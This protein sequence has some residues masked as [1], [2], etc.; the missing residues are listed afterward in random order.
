MGGGGWGGGWFG[1]VFGS[2]GGAISDAAQTVM[3]GV[4]HVSPL[5][6]HLTDPL[7]HILNQG[8]INIPGTDLS[9]SLA[10]MLMGPLLAIPYELWRRVNS[11]D[12]SPHVSVIPLSI[13]P[14]FADLQ[15]YINN[16]NTGLVA[17]KTPGDFSNPSEVQKYFAEDNTGYNY[18]DVCVTVPNSTLQLIFSAS[19]FAKTDGF[20]NINVCYLGTEESCNCNSPTEESINMMGVGFSSINPQ[21]TYPVSC[22]GMSYVGDNNNGLSTGGR[23]EVGTLNDAE[24]QIIQK[25]GSKYSTDIDIND[26]AYN[27]EKSR[28]LDLVYTY[29]GTTWIRQQN[30]LE[31][32][33]YHT[34]VGNNTHAIF[35]GG[36][37]DTLTNYSFSYHDKISNIP[38][39]NF[40]QFNFDNKYTTQILSEKLYGTHTDSA[41]LKSSCWTNPAWN[42]HTNFNQ[43]PYMIVDN[44]TYTPS[45]TTNYM[46]FIRDADFPLVNFSSIQPN[47]SFEFGDAVKLYKTVI[48][49]TICVSQIDSGGWGGWG[50]SLGVAIDGIFGGGGWDGYCNAYTQ[51]KQVSETL[52]E[53]ISGAHVSFIY[54]TIDVMQITANFDAAF[55]NSRKRTKSTTCCPAGPPRARPR[56]PPRSLAQPPWAAMPPT[57]HR[58]RRARLTSK[59]RARQGAA[60]K[61]WSPPL[62]PLPPPPP[63]PPTTTRRRRTSTS[64]P[65]PRPRPPCL[66]SRGPR[67]RLPTRQQHQLPHP[68]PLVAL[69]T[70]ARRPRSGRRPSAAAAPPGG[71]PRPCCPPTRAAGPPPPWRARGGGPRRRPTRRPARGGTR[72]TARRRPSRCSPGRGPRRP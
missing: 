13:N 71:A 55:K 60:A 65:L 2:I 45:I 54:P 11:I 66:G 48:A 50:G 17:F 26:T 7:S 49:G 4:E 30:L 18:I 52:P 27:L 32:V 38:V 51:S 36:I 59:P 61:R 39:P 69:S 5:I 57:R 33:Y 28:V 37:H 68:P 19:D 10:D 14:Y 46:G 29:N 21:L 72:A 63:P 53:A 58:A 15:I 56:P 62:P 67:Q 34:G 70:A 43:D 44:P 12:F 64:M 8:L 6:N 20:V 23:C 9:I 25:Y 3:D 41:L 22:H 40:D 42:D 35:F 31:S 1:D 16:E 24:S 47:A